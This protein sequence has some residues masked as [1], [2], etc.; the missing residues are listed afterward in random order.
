MKYLRQFMVIL[1]ISFLGELLKFFLPFPIPASIY[2]M[3][4]LFV[5]LLSGIIPLDAVR[6]TGKFLIEIMP[7]MFI[8]AGVGVMASWTTLKPLLFPVS[9]IMVVVIFTVMAAT[10]KV[11]QFVIKYE[12]KKEYKENNG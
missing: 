2:G 11:S 7:V 6:E 3:L 12:K 5:G 10:G 4:I 1:F 9:V 8:P